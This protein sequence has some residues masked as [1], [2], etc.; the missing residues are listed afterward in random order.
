[1]PARGRQSTRASAS[2]HI[3]GYIP[4]I[5][6]VKF[7]LPAGM[8]AHADRPAID[9]PARP[10]QRGRGSSWPWWAAAGRPMG[11]PSTFRELSRFSKAPTI[12]MVI[13]TA[14]GVRP[15]AICSLIF[16]RLGF[17]DPSRVIVLQEDSARR[18]GCGRG[19]VAAT[20][21]GL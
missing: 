9:H 8:T 2:N 12:W 3:L 11:Y 16:D 10:E 18:C 5:H 6:S 4:G 15:C 17:R 14:A 20:G 19:K 13:A 21:S 7:N 1:M